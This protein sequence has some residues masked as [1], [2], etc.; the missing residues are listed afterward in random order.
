A[1]PL[2]DLAP[3]V[4]SEHVGDEPFTGAIV[5]QIDEVTEDQKELTGSSQPGES[6]ELAMDVRDDQHSGRLRGRIGVVLVGADP[7][8]VPSRGRPS[9]H[10]EYRGDGPRD[11]QWRELARHSGHAESRHGSHDPATWDPKTL[12]RVDRV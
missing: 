11:V 5:D 10:G 4:I 12:L 1:P 3:E 9:Q 2:R 8:G 6:T 7:A